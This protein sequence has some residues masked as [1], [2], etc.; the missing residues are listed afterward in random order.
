MLGA[1]RLL[2]MSFLG[3]FLVT[4]DDTEDQITLVAK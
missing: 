2:R 3:R 4:L 1:K